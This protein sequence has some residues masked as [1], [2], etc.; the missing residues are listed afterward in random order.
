MAA[1]P[2]SK[3]VCATC[4]SALQERPAKRTHTHPSAHL[5]L[6]DS[7]TLW[8][9]GPRWLYP[10]IRV[11]AYPRI[12]VSAYPRIRLA[13]RACIR[14][15]PPLSPPESP[16]CSLA[17][18]LGGPTHARIGSPLLPARAYA[19]ER[20]RQQA[21]L[22]ARLDQAAETAGAV[23]WLD[24]LDWLVWLVWLLAARSQPLEPPLRPAQTSVCGLSIRALNRPLVA[25]VT[26]AIQ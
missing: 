20:A 18:Q 1:Q 13:A 19:L 17:R 9:C 14:P 23:D 15:S 4:R 5:G 26:S 10:R 3:V 12:C 8:R 16:R 24:W 7:P 21:R 2:A 11:S 6:S 25:R 22:R